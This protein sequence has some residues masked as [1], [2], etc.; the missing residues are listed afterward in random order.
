MTFQN[1]M[2]DDVVK[3][4]FKDVHLT[5]EHYYKYMFTFIGH[6]TLS[7]RYKIIAQYGGNHDDIYKFE[8]DIHE[9]LCFGKFGL[10]SFSFVEIY[11]YDA[12]N[13]PTFYT[14]IYEHLGW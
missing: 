1:Q 9:P 13:P 3:F 7:E 12:M 10:D 2:T 11:K 8:V 5:F 14:K 4:L 6:E